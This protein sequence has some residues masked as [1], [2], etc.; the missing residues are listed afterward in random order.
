MF[1]GKLLFEPFQPI[2]KTESAST[3]ANE[4]FIDLVDQCVGG[5]HIFHSTCPDALACGAVDREV[6]AARHLVQS[7]DT[8]TE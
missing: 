3:P 2:S 8:S 7:P 1:C 6:T 4:W 5:V